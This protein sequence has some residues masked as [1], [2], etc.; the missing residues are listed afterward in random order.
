MASVPRLAAERCAPA[1][2][3]PSSNKMALITWIVMQRGSV[4]IK[5][6]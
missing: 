3:G 1:Q 2:H 5:W 4:S 6:F